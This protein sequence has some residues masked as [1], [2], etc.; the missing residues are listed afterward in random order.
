MPESPVTITARLLTDYSS[1]PSGT[2]RNILSHR[3]STRHNRQKS[4]TF[5][6][7]GYTVMTRPKVVPKV[8]KMTPPVTDSV[9]PLIARLRHFAQ[10][11]RK[12]D[13][14][15]SGGFVTFAQSGT[16]LAWSGAH[17][18]R[19]VT[20]SPVLRKSDGIAKVTESPRIVFYVGQGSLGPGSQGSQDPG[21]LGSQE[22]RKPRSRAW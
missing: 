6:F 11:C 18:F 15:D 10:K 9:T 13:S 5:H 22:A 3:Y 8:T 2:N 19:K 12:C 21:S 14:D 16:L 1:G 20:E 4:E 17:L 7:G